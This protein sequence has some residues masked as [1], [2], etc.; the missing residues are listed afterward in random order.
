MC[1]DEDLKYIKNNI[2]YISY[3]PE[4]NFETQSR[5]LFKILRDTENIDISEIYVHINNNINN[6]FC[7]LKTAVYNRLVRAAGFNIINLI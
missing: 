4:N 3:G 5:N 2:K 7:D 1:F 6:N